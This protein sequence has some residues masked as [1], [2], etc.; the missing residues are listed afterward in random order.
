V[1]CGDL[2]FVDSAPAATTKASKRT[3]HEF[4]V[5]TLSH[6]LDHGQHGAK[7]RLKHCVAGKDRIISRAQYGD[8]GEA[9]AVCLLGRINFL[10]MITVADGRRLP[11]RRPNAKT[12]A[13]SRAAISGPSSNA[14]VPDRRRRRVSA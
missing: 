11:L 12:C 5:E 3:W 1:F 6:G 2:C 13:L 9:T 4:D 14:I 8:G 10:R 7:E